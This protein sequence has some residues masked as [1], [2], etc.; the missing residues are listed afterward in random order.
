[1]KRKLGNWPCAV[2]VQHCRRDSIA[3][4]DGLHAPIATR[5]ASCFSTGGLTGAWERE[6]DSLVYRDADTLRIAKRLRKHWDFLFTFLDKPEVP[7]D[8]NLAERA[9]RPAVI[10][11]KNSQSNRSEQG[12]APQTVLMVTSWAPTARWACAVSIPRK[13][14]PSPCEPTFRP[15]NGRP[16]PASCRV[17]RAHHLVRVSQILDHAYR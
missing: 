16:Y 17:G 12:A 5:A 11:R 4:A 8:N 3:Q 6:D 1:M 9:I 10:L 15:A 2:P 7:F 13:P 14:S